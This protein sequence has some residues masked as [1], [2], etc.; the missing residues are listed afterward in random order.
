MKKDQYI[1]LLLIMV[2]ILLFAAWT[3]A[4]SE[5][6][7]NIPLGVKS[8]GNI[9][10]NGEFE[11]HVFS[12]D[13]WQH[14]GNIAFGKFFC[15]KELDLN[16]YLSGSK[17]VK[18][19]IVQQG[20]GAAH[21]DSVLIGGTPPIAVEG[22]QD[23]LKKL[24]KKDF[25]VVDAFGKKILITFPEVSKDSVLKL[26]A[27]V[28]NKVISKTPFQ[29]PTANLYKKMDANSA[30]Y[31]YQMNAENTL[32]PFF[33][34]Y[35][36][37]GSGHPS[38]YTYGWVRNDDKNLYVK[39]D[40]TPDNTMDGDKDYAKVYVKTKEGLKEFKVSVPE[41]KWGTP[42]F[43]YTDK[44]SYQ[45]KVYDFTIPIK[46]LNIN[47]VKEEKELFLAF[48]AYG[49]ATPPGDYVNDIAYDSV[50]N[51]YLIV[52]TNVY[53]DVAENDQFDIYAQLLN[54]NG[55]PYSS[56]F[57]ICAAAYDQYHP[58]VAFDPGN[59]RYLVVWYDQRNTFLSTT[60]G[61]I[62]GRLVNAD[63][64]SLYGNEIVISNAG[65]EQLYPD[66]AYSP[67]SQKYLVTWM[68]RRDFDNGAPGDVYGQIVDH[69]GTLYGPT[70]DVNFVISS[71]SG[72][73]QF[74]PAVMPVIAYDSQE[75]RFLV[76]WND[77]QN[78][79][80]TGV[81]IHG[82]LVSASG[83]LIDNNTLV[84]DT[85]DA[86][87][88]SIAYSHYNQK[89][90]VAWWQWSSTTMNDIFGQLVNT[91][92][93]P[94]GSYFPI[95]DQADRQYDPSIAYDTAN[96]RY[97]VTFWDERDR[98]TSGINIY[99]QY[100]N[101]D[102]TLSGSDSN[103]NFVISDAD[104]DQMENSVAYNSNFSNFLIAFT[105]HATDPY[106][107]STVLLGPPCQEGCYWLGDINCDDAIDISDV[108][109]VLRL[110]L[111]LDPPA[112]CSDINSDG[113]VDISDVILTLR[114]ALGLDEKVPC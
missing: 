69:N 82:Q 61:D 92:G 108:I 107:I 24:S 21:I 5:A 109:L 88:I 48:A 79:L 41:T 83:S 51:R 27:R 78:A 67:D 65:N 100:V 28:E 32:S 104:G 2:V 11:I 1:R 103:E 89:F 13:K 38:G 17:E 33:K 74:F 46:D 80:T 18:V 39:I 102:G 106:E 20:G 7:Q 66:V 62:Y 58:R 97:L 64:G 52:F 95:S 71:G 113:G 19:R 111:Q 60:A 55:T 40:F 86:N 44:V 81:E 36:L 6:T 35:S 42:N 85:A 3:V 76:I 14:A 99:G 47:D 54:C 31:K 94:Y 30:F 73:T 75:N 50:N 22:V 96:K 29:F 98:S 25:D 91:D 9:T 34:E 45:H 23:G 49:T 4:A 59:K 112:Q 53:F 70:S 8:V 101:Y 37:T 72:G 84:S 57:A 110:A 16:S 114:T 26:T 10:P 43:T 12:Q 63:D 15:E 90:L 77:Y 93:T 87:S 68:D 105:T 56:P